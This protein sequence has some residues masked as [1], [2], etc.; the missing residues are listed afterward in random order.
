MRY[1]R[2][3][4]LSVLAAAPLGGLAT[5]LATLWDDISVRHTVNATLANWEALGVSPAGT[6]ID[7]YIALK[8]Q[9]ESALTDALYEVSTPGH[10][11]Y[12]YAALPLT[13]ALTCATSPFQIW[14]I[15]VQ[16]AGC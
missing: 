11:K 8:A 2:P 1:P 10:P 7:L 4:V 5:P 3:S 16:G 15:P 12:V 13:P 14:L 9:H 6:T